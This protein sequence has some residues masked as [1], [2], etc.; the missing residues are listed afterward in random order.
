MATVRWDYGVLRFAEV[1]ASAINKPS[2]T[3]E[4][5]KTD[6]NGQVSF[7][8]AFCEQDEIQLKLNSQGCTGV[9]TLPNGLI[10]GITNVDFLVKCQEE[11]Y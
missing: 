10:N 6:E 5:L 3:P 11:E 4:K 8:E 7:T 1:E 2:S 9:Y